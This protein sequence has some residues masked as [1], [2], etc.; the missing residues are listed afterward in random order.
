MRAAAL[1]AGEVF[2]RFRPWQKKCAFKSFEVVAEMPLPNG[3]DGALRADEFEA[4][5]D[6]VEGQELGVEC[7]Q[8]I[9]EEVEWA[10]RKRKEGTVW[11]D[12][13]LGCER[14]S[15]KK[16]IILIVVAVVVLVG[17]L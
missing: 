12:A 8:G 10:G 9:L 13:A 17:I 15:M 16:K 7:L 6:R 2:R 14:G 3:R 1:G 11:G 5:P 4:G